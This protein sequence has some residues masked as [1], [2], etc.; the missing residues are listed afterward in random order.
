MEK[1]VQFMIKYLMIAAFYVC[2]C[3]LLDWY[4]DKYDATIISY[5]LLMLFF[6]FTSI[7]VINL[8]Y[9]DSLFS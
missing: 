7:V 9:I 8:A 5:I 1:F 3:V 4:A 2:Y 6:Y